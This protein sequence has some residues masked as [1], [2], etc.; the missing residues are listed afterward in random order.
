[1]IKSTDA[2]TGAYM[3]GIRSFFMIMLLTLF[4][5]ACSSTKTAVKPSQFR[6]VETTLAKGIEDMETKGIPVKPTTTFTTK[7]KEVVSHVKYVNLTGKHHL[8][9]KWFTPGGRL[10]YAT[11][12]YPIKTSKNTYV[13]EGS[14]CHTISIKGTKAEKYPGDWKVNIYLDDMLTASTSFIIKETKRVPKPVAVKIPDIDFGN[15]HALVIGNNN[16]KYLTNLKSAKNDAK[17]V[18][19]L[20]K[21]DYGFNVDMLIDATRSDIL[22]SLGK[23]RRN[24]SKQDNLLIYYAGHGWLDKEADEGYW[25]PVDAASDNKINWVSNSSITS[26]LKAMHTKHVLIVA[27]SCYSGKLTRGIHVKIRTQNYFS[28]IAKKRA[29]SVLSSGGLEPVYDSGG[30]QG[31]SVFA[32]AFLDVL[33]ENKGVVDATEL[34]SKLRRPVMLNADQ[35][36]EYSDIRK[37]GH[38]G[39]DFLFVRKVFT[40]SRP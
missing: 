35:T 1:M 15:Y 36:P 24:L 29:R 21:H 19:H 9:W 8:K 28:T 2:T 17:A 13:K 4:V 3:D 27:D 5:F 25:L 11:S 26:T 16:Y 18:A 6:I 10:Y 23:M 31:Y 12:N 14:S 7:D 30:K 40:P 39:G 37:A 34:F 22:L 38:D 33:E 32:S 20:L